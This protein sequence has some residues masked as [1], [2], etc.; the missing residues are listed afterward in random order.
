[1]DSF[2][3][4]FSKI[5]EQFPAVFSALNEGFLQTLKLFGI[6]LLGALPLGL[7]I[8]FGS[9][10]RFKPLSILTKVIVWIVRGTPLMIQLLIIF[11]F[12]GLVFQANIWGRGESGRFLAASIAFILNYAC[13]FSEIYRGG[14]Q[15][16]P[17]GQK[18]AAQVLGL[19]KTQ[20]FFRV[21]LLQMIKRIV[22]PM[23]NEIITLVKDTSLARIIALQEVIWAGQAFMKGSRGISG[24]IWPL[25]FTGIYYLVFSGILTLLFAYIEKKLDYFKT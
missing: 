6:T 10:S 8:S 3:S 11:Y 16:V 2:M 7:I 17:H 14:I 19:S 18:E 5:Y 9:M 25:F 4:L 20:T 12:P 24:E 22:P 23:S 21:T 1:M 13:Y 15:G